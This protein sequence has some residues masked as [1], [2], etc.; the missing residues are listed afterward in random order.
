MNPDIS[1][2]DLEHICKELKLTDEQTKT[3]LESYDWD[4]TENTLMREIDHF[5]YH[6]AVEKNQM[7]MDV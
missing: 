7:R 5:V 4:A 3:V 1:S 6:N 2:K